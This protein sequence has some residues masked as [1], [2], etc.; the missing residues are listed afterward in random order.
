MICYEPC[1]PTRW[2]S[3]PG[4]YQ[5]DRLCYRTAESKTKAERPKDFST[6]PKR[7]QPGDG[8]GLVLLILKREKKELSEFRLFLWRRSRVHLSEAT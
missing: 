8:P 7:D 2:Y 3:Q 6:G 4:I 5:L 1:R